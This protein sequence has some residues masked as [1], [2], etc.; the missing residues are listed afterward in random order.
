[1]PAATRRLHFRSPLANGHTRNRLKRI[2]VALDPET[3]ARLRDRAASTDQPLG[4][5]ASDLI[6]QG[7]K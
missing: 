5:I 4:W 6:E 7:L 3:F 2:T 1:M